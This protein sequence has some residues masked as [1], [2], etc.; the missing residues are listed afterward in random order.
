[1]AGKRGGGAGTRGQRQ[2]IAVID[3]TDY[4]VAILCQRWQEGASAEQI[5]AE[6]DYPGMKAAVTSKATRMG[7]TRGRKEAMAKVEA[8]VAVVPEHAIKRADAEP[9]KPV[10][11]YVSILDKAKWK[12]GW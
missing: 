6:I 7:L 10:L 9:G 3:W 4:R 5:A 8:V 11:P 1:M 2:G 12:Q